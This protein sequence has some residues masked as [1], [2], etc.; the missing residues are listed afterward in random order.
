M[1]AAQI[2]GHHLWREFLGAVSDQFSMA[3]S[4]SQR[5]ILFQNLLQTVAQ[6]LDAVAQRTY[7]ETNESDAA[8]GPARTA[9]NMRKTLSTR[10]AIA[11]TINL[12]NSLL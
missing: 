7:Y 12:R 11:H 8:C 9:R 5:M 2:E 4:L 1:D 6:Q 3:V 10:S